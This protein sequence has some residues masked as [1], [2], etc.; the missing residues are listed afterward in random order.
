MNQFHKQVAGSWAVLRNTNLICTHLSQ[1]RLVQKF[2]PSTLSNIPRGST[3]S[4]PPSCP[5]LVRAG[6]V[7]GPSQ[8]WMEGTPSPG[9]ELLPRGEE[10]GR[11][12]ITLGSPP[13]TVYSFFPVFYS[14]S[15]SYCYCYYYYYD[16]S[17]L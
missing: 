17:L 13:R 6:T 14:Y 2:Q 3:I 15:S 11:P 5:N 9:T 1:R 4:S 7:S 8:G 16:Y 10:T 12:P